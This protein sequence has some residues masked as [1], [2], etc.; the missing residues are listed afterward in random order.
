MKRFMLLLVVL[1][2]MAILGPT[3]SADVRTSGPGPLRTDN[4]WSAY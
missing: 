1:L 2:A 3:A 4:S